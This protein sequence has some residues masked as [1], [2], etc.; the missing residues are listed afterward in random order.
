[1]TLLLAGSLAPAVS[2]QSTSSFEEFR[3]SL[4]NDYEQFRQTILSHYADFLNGTWHEYEPLAPLKRDHTPKP[5]KVPDIKVSKP[6][7]TPKRMP[8]PTLAELPPSLRPA[9]EEEQPAVEE[10]PSE[11][12]SL[13]PET[14]K[15]VVPPEAGKV[16]PPTLKVRPDVGTPLLSALPEST[17]PAP[18]LPV[19][20]GGETLPVGAN[21]PDGANIANVDLKPITLPEEEVSRVGK[22]PV[23]FYGME[24]L[25]PQVDFKIMPTFKTVGDFARNWKLLEEQNAKTDIIDAVMPMVKELRLNDY[26]TYEFLCAYMDGKFPET[27]YASKLSAVHY[28]LANL[29]YNARIGMTAG[30]GDAVLMMPTKQTI[31]GKPLMTVGG[32]KYCVLAG[33]GVNPMGQMI[34]TC[35]LPKVADKAKKFDLVINELNLPVRESPFE[36]NYGGI[37]LSGTVNANLMPVVY[38]YPQMETSD[39][40]ISELDGGLRR[41]LVS[42]LKEQLSDKEKL[43]ATNQLLQFVQSGFD[44]ATDDDF[45][46]F[47]KPYFLE[48]NLYY[49][50][51][52]CEDRAI[53]YTYLLWHALGVESQLLFFPGH[54]SVGVALDADIKGTSYEHDGRRY[55]ISDPTYIGSTTGMCMPQY[56]STAPVIDLAIPHQ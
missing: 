35:D 12:P 2:A 20:P 54:E 47:E 14:P 46:G 52:D 6:S 26:L 13:I 34:S 31:Y 45:H 9:V 11:K 40:A 29:G 21:V 32:E 44:Y 18:K 33:P 50:K 39:Y 24:F 10:Q 37:T 3:Q 22:E 43:A 8:S 51:N 28:I 41:N 36:V 49:P 7:V 5:M 55:F 38:R 42:Q 56:V 30:T 1:M 23:M 15:P 4:Y 53:F 48:E 19:G 16:T 27:S 25:V 17:R